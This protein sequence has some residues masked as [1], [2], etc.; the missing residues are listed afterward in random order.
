MFAAALPQSKQSRKIFFHLIELASLK[1]STAETSPSVVTTTFIPNCI[2]E[3]IERPLNMVGEDL[4][5]YL[6]KSF[7][8]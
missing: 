3:T 1:P 8:L 7:E 2:A 4:L 6:D 5:V